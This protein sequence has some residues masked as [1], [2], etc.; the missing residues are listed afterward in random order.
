MLANVCN[1]GEQV[2]RFKVWNGSSCDLLHRI[3]LQTSSR[4]TAE[5]HTVHH[6][7]PTLLGVERFGHVDVR[8]VCLWVMDSTQD[9]PLF[10]FF[11]AFLQV[12]TCRLVLPR[13][14]I[15]PSSWCQLVRP[16]TYLKS[17]DVWAE[18]KPEKWNSGEN[19]PCMS[20]ASACKSSCCDWSKVRGTGEVS[21]YGMEWEHFIGRSFG[22]H[23][24]GSPLRLLEKWTG[25]ILLFCPLKASFRIE[26][27]ASVC[28][29]SLRL[30]LAGTIFHAAALKRLTPSA[31]RC[32]CSLL[33]RET[34]W[35]AKVTLAVWT[36]IHTHR[37]WLM[38]P[39]GNTAELLWPQLSPDWLMP[40]QSGRS[41]LFLLVDVDTFL[42][43]TL[44]GSLCDW[45]M[46][47]LTK[48]SAVQKLTIL[49]K[50]QWNIWKCP[51]LLLEI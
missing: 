32:C 17:K 23:L 19:E 40:S 6:L 4:V 49:H 38:Q 35:G 18:M 30:L 9:S 25:W 45:V 22:W 8:Q 10:F 43:L 21:F 33:T 13:A 1:S 11:C 47:L 37:F 12:C 36:L 27:G 29:L 34:C 50:W 24:P 20:L 41:T 46:V 2:Y 44:T 5:S 3:F 26:V 51:L 31:R 48:F 14:S 15:G 7:Q 16:R 28:D 42:I 39:A